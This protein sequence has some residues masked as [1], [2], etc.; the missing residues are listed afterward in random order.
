MSGISEQTVNAA[1]VKTIEIEMT[2][3]DLVMKKGEN[4]IEIRAVL[5]KG[6]PDKFKV[7]QNGD[8]LKLTYG[9]KRKSVKYKRDTEVIELYVPEQMHAEK[10][11]IKV[12]AGECAVSVPGFTIDKMHLE[13]GAGKLKAEDITVTGTAAVEVG[14]GK[15]KLTQIS[16]EILTINCGVGE[17]KYEG[18]VSRDVKADCGVGE[19]S[20]KLAGKET[21]YNYEVS[22]GIGK[23]KVNDSCYGSFATSKCV[24]HE[25]A[26]GT[27][28][29]E[30]GVGKIKIETEK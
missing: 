16:A 30:C 18:S 3:A 24:Q 13:V 5:V 14:A 15:M 17:C 22:C 10:L 23:I 4:D 6:E 21:D 20:V 29:L 1:E 19:V 12:G 26:K 11:S 8:K 9:M 27:M 2:A 7:E 25:Q 28:K